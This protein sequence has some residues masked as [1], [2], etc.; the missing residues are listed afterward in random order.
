MISSR[1]KILVTAIVSVIIIMV[2]A[3][4]HFALLSSDTSK[5][6]IKIGFVYDSDEVTP[7][8]ANFIKAQK[9]IE[10]QLG[11]KAVVSVKANIRDSD[12]GEAEIGQL[13][14]EGC[15]IIFTTSYGYGAAAKKLAALN[16]GIQ[17]CEATCDNADDEPFCENYH[18][19]MGEIYQGRYISGAVAGLKLQEMIDR[20]EIAADA[21]KLGYVAAFPNAEVISGY[22]AF[23]LGARSVCPTA[24]MDVKYTDTWSNYAI[25]KRAAKELI[26][27]GCV[28]ISQHSD[29]TGP[30]VACEEVFSEKSVYHVGY[31]SSMIDVA[32]T[33]SLISSRIN[34][35]PYMVAA[36]E[37]VLDDK[38]IEDHVKGHIHGNDIGAGFEHGWIEMQDL[39]EII[40]ADGSRELIDRLIKDFSDESLEVFKGPYTGVDPADPSRTV[41]LTDGYTE[42]ENSSAPTFCYVLN[43]VIRILE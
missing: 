38:R 31:N 43:D 10:R 19:F 23:F 40:A 25:E 33:S 24:T 7:Y 21:A 28:I 42:N 41:D 11:S 27:G 17:F 8:T 1:R 12:G 26:D 4:I 9:A 18:T 30:A 29:T 2:F 22:T 13:I 5:Q 16:P 35:E 34:W 14:A 32:P 36:C 6:S 15:D 39:N 3:I 20:G 37:A